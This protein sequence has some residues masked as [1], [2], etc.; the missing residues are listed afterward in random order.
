MPKS[1]WPRARFSLSPTVR[2]LVLAAAACGVAVPALAALEHEEVDKLMQAGKL[3]EAMTKADA[4]LKDKPRD[5]QMRFLKGVIQLDTGK[6]NEA[7]AAFTQL[8]LDAPE[9]P[10]PY[11]NLA[12][13]YASQ[14][15]FDKARNALESA[16]RTNPSYAT[17]Q[18]NLGD[19][20][21]RLASQ[22][23][24]KALQLDQGNTAVQPKLAVIRTLFTPTPPGGKPAALVASAA[25][26][27]TAPAPAPA[28][29]AKAPPP[30]PAPAPAAPPPAKV[31][32]APA[33][34]AAAPKAPEA[35]A[36]APAPA[37]A[38]AAAPAASTAANAEIESAVRAWASAWA[39]QDMDRYLAAYG[40]DFAPG[41]GQNRKSWEQDRRARIVGKSSISV[42]IENLAIKVDGDSATAKFRQIYRADNLNVSSRKTLEMQR[43]GNQWHIRKESVGG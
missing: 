24:S 36:P 2:A 1:P 26:T 39:S 32:A 3:D 10:E 4:F 22:A 27:A 35:A 7:I 30:A 18:E 40:N 23:Y 21:A 34:V 5:P 14:N 41:G 43:S 31:A 37:P 38:A 42:N 12:V 11:N 8:T 33:P 17:A 6:R 25:P 29:V 9:L 13:I 16:I 28:P 19:V 20:Y 15:Q